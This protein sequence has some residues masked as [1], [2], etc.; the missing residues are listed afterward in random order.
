MSATATLF[1][2]WRKQFP[3]CCYIYPRGRRQDEMCESDSAAQASGANFNP[4]C[5][6][7]AAYWRDTLEYQQYMEEYQRA[8]KIDNKART[9]V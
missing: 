9:V 5:K 7:H 8:V 1:E 3:K 6:K 4:F 2:N